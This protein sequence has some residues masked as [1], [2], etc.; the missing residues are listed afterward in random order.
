MKKNI[1]VLLLIGMLFLMNSCSLFGQE[2]MQGIDLPLEKMNDKLKLTAPRELS[3]FKI[4]D[5]LGLVLTNLSDETIVL[6]QDYGVHIYQNVD[7]QWEAVEN[8][9]DYGEGEKVMLAENHQPFRDAI[10]VVTPLVFSDQPVKI[11]VVIVG[12]YQKSNGKMGDDVGAY[13]DITLQP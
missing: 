13:I 11:R 4:G 1:G 2:R 7:N 9:I 5:D 3:S 6:P 10:V 12:Q 8:R